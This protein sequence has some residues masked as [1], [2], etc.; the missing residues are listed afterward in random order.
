MPSATVR[1]NKFPKSN[2]C[3]SR[4]SGRRGKWNGKRVLV[5]IELQEESKY[6]CDHPND[7]FM[8]E[9]VNDLSDLLQR[10]KNAKN[11]LTSPTCAAIEEWLIEY[12]KRLVKGPSARE[13]DYRE[14]LLKIDDRDRSSIHRCKFFST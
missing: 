1:V 10:S 2:W 14:G 6:M 8:T 12:R 11:G 13:Y 4:R 5:A 7:D 3:Y 9:P